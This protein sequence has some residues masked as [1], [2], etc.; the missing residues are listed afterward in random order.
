MSNDLTEILNADLHC[1][2][3]QSDGTLQ[4]AQL[5]KRAHERGVELWALTDHD[6][7]S[8]I[9]CARLAAQELG[10]R[11]V[12]GVE[13]SVTWANRTLHVVGLGIDENNAILLQGLAEIRSGREGRAK[14]MAAKLADLGI[15]GALEGALGY[16][17]NPDLVSRTH[18]ARFLYDQGHGTSMQSIF[19][20][21]LAEGAIAHVPTQ[22]ATLEQAL[23]W[24]NE[25]G[26]VAVIAHPGR[27]KYTELQY[28]A[29]FDQFKEL[30]GQAIEVNTG[31][32]AP[33]QN[34]QY[35]QVARDYGFW[36]SMG[37]DFHGP[38]ESRHDLG[39]LDRLPRDL[40]PVWHLLNT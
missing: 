38:Q 32:H 8:G 27:Y 35:A 29:L 1:H 6:E 4:P 5:A 9:A 22:W 3:I 28:G 19:D 40:K 39:S 33:G 37:S 18:F 15:E 25:A 24:I 11:F 2:S 14:T 31:S 30:G 26:G 34:E 12:A 20:R 23:H 16:V 13:I 36:A 10:L 17:R 21:Y 7:V